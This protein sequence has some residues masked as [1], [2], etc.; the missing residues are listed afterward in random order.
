MQYFQIS[1]LEGQILDLEHF[2]AIRMRGDNIQR[3]LNEWDYVVAGMRKQPS[4]EEM[5]LKF[6]KD[7][8][9]VHELKDVPAVQT[10]L[11]AIERKAILSVAAIHGQRSFGGKA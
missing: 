6:R 4:E 1:A 2:Q 3:Y 8:E 9:H 7:L 11:Y 5:E 10:T